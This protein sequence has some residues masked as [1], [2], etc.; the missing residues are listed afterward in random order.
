MAR[1]ARTRL[2]RQLTAILFGAVFEDSRARTSIDWISGL[3]SVDY[4]RRP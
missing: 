4:G 2:R 3:E 1:N